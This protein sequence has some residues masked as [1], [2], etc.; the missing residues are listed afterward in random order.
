MFWCHLQIL[1]EIF[2][3][4]RR[5]QRDTV[6]NLQR[7]SYKVTV[8]IVRFL[9]NLEFFRQ[10]FGKY[11]N[12]KFYGNPISGSRVVPCGTTD[13]R[14][15]MTKLTVAFRN[16]VNAPKITKVNI[17]FINLCHF[18]VEYFCFWKRNEIAIQGLNSGKYDRWKY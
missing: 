12:T 16:F 2:L 11:S 1:T 17:G 9:M 10:I 13:R 8:I 6:I 18:V 7:C 5:I 15:D 3:N 14:T 4:L